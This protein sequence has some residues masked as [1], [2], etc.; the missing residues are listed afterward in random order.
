[1]CSCGFRFCDSTL[2][3]HAFLLFV[4]SVGL[5]QKVDALL[6]LVGVFLHASPKVIQFGE[7]SSVVKAIVALIALALGGIIGDSTPT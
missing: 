5:E 1:M 4:E 6:A 3:Q 7:S 2:K